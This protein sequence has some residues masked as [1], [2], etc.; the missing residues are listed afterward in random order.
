MPNP[1]LPLWEHVPDGEPRVFGD[2]VYLYGSH[3]NAYSQS[4]CDMRLKVWSAP[5]N[6]LNNWVC[7]GDSFHTRT[8][9]DH[10]PSVSWCNGELYAPDVVEK[11]GKYYLFAYLFYAKGCVAVSDRPEGP[12]TLCSKYKYDEKEAAEQKRYENGVFVDPGVLIDDDGQAYIYCGYE[13][14][15]AAKLDPD[16]LSRVIPGSYVDNILPVEE[17][18][19]FFEACSPR[20]IGD[21]YYLIYSPRRGSCLAYATA[22]APLGPYEYRGVIIDNGIDYPGGN[23]HGSIVEIN[24]QWYV[25]YHRTSNNT[26][27]SRQACAERITILADGSIP[28]VEMTSLGFSKSLSP[29]AA[30]PAA[31]ACVLTGG[32][33][34]KQKSPLTTIISGVKNG[35]VIGYKYFDFG[36]D[37]SAT[38]TDMYI[39]L[40]GTG[41]NGE[42]EVL[43]DDKENGEIIGKA[44]ISGDDETLRLHMRS[45][46]GR[47]A[48]YIRFTD[49]RRQDEYGFAGRELCSLCEFCFVK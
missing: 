7:H 25:F 47:H 12:F 48:L 44:V 11:D 36:V 45:L 34:I 5:V 20:K 37:Y 26:V 4:F 31:Y 40:L 10:E 42:L 46:S 24:G 38:S 23:D 18:F 3:D 41:E 2:R 17:P 13:R 16:D 1:I 14:S 33:Y 28:Q 35:S 15:Y 9:G 49:K 30:T 29:Y 6:D 32:A 39:K 8:D 27:H 43:L 19:R 21:T 22:K